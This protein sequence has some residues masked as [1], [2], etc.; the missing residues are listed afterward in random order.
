MTK[1]TH[2]YLWLMIVPALS[3]V[4]AGPKAASAGVIRVP[5]DHPTI[6]AAIDASQ[7]GDTVLLAEGTYKG[8]GNKSLN[9]NGKAITVRSEKGPWKCIIDCEQYGNG[10]IF[11]TGEGPN[12]ILN[13]VTITNGRTL[14]GGA[15]TIKESSPTIT[16]CIFLNNQGKR[17]R[18]IDG[19]GGAI[20]CYDDVLINKR[21]PWTDYGPCKPSI[22][23]C[24]FSENSADYGGAIY[25]YSDG[26]L[27]ETSPKIIHCT[28]ADNHA[29]L[30]GGGLYTWLAE[31]VVK[32]TIFW[33]NTAGTF[34]PEIRTIGGSPLILYCDVEGGYPGTGN[35][36]RD[37]Y[38]VGG[39]D[40]HLEAGSPC[41]NQGTDA[42]VYSDI[43]GN[44][45]PLLGGFD[46]GADEYSGPCWDS[47]SDG[48]T[49]L[50]CGGN[51]C[52]DNNANIFP[53]S[54]NP[55]CTCEEPYPVGTD[56]IPRDS[57]DN[58][59]N[60]LIDEWN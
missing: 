52:D 16:N 51:D 37:P 33:N 2:L 36:D 59:C 3:V 46:I 58:N 10:F 13:G 30:E 31:P 43:D 26:R 21:N 22:T 19:Y 47:D 45:R 56:E 18:G 57:I 7:S 29:D 20:Y 11:E 15:I 39:G 42:G 55:F 12:S 53:G 40:Y 44:Q 24:I 25:C 17:K 28:I 8:P 54:P 23:N 60:G 32:N 14:Y 48:F 27:S 41:I 5:D 6:Q 4:L 1:T 9:F 49:N 34:F 50:I 38:F 35:I